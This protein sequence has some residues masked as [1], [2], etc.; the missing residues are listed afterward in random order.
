MKLSKQRTSLD[1]LKF[2]FSQ[3][4][5]QEW[6]KLSQDV[7]DAMSV[8]HIRNRLDKFWRRYGH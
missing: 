1:A 7:V 4:V 5:M 3:R 8:N 6:N 2:S